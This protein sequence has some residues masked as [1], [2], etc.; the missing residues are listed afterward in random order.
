M[1]LDL[2]HLYE[3]MLR[4]RLFEEGVRTLWNEGLISGEMHLSLGEEAIVAGVVCQLEDGDAMALDHRGTAPLLMRGVGPVSLLRELLGRKDGL[5]AGQGGHMHLFSRKHLAASSGIVG[6]SGPAGVGFALAAQHLRPGKLAVAFFGEGA[7]NQGM[8]LE[9]MNLAVVWKL[10]LVLV[11]KDNQWAITTPSSTV[12]GGTL[13]E[14]AKGFGMPAIASDGIDVRAMWEA[15]REAIQRARNGD[16]PTFIHARCVHIE[17]H[18]LGD[19]LFRAA[20]SPVKETMPLAG[21]LIKSIV[22]RQGVPLSERLHA[23]TSVTRRIQ[24]AAKDSSSV[25]NDPVLRARRALSLDSGQ[26]DALEEKV[27]SEI[28]SAVESALAD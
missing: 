19:Q 13:T 25:E 9:A 18:F 2:I 3:Q 4:S 23:L 12:T 26:L 10:P 28:V 27:R 17:G 15:A 5:C 16:G 24:D 21:P 22:T 6:A 7:V 11:C 14:R 8:L 20:R 1:S